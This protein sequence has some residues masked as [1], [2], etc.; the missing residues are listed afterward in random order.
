[1][2]HKLFQQFLDKFNDLFSPDD[3]NF[4]QEVKQHMRTSM[5]RA[6]EKLD[7]VTREEF[8][9]QSTVLSRSREKIDLLEQKLADIE[10]KLDKNMTE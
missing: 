10:R 7:V 5:M 1:M 4:G 3:N 9:A 8:D 6:F 2:D